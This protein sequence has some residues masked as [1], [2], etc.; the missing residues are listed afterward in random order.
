MSVSVVIKNAAST[1]GEG[2]HWVP[3]ARVLWHVD[4]TANDV[5]RYDVTTGQDSKVH[6]DD[7][8]SFVTPTKSNPE[9]LVIGLGRRISLLD[10][11]TGSVSHLTDE[12]DVGTK[13]RFNDGKCDPSGRL[14]AGTMGHEPRPG[15]SAGGLER[16]MG[17]LYSLTKGQ[18]KHHLGKID[19]SNGLDWTSDHRTMFY[20]DSVPRKVYAFDFDITKG[21]ISNQRVAVD[22]DDGP[23]DRGVPDGCCLDAEDK[24]WVACYGGGCVIRFDPETGK[25]LQQVKIPAKR[26][27]SCCFGGDN[28][29][30]LYVTCGKFGMTEEEFKN[31]QPLAGSVFKVTGLGVKGKPMFCYED[32]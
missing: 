1:T 18:L 25:E 11:K 21:E 13:N 16:H 26:T 23:Q 27:T 30:E 7:T 20:I 32:K 10:W 2:P 5:H 6:L 22:F 4:I 19:I 14:W 28:L 12:L 24:L 8:V 17:S 15:G 3:G 29:D 31:E 9:S